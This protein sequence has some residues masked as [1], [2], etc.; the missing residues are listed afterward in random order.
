MSRYNNTSRYALDVSNQ[1]ASRIP[2]SPTS[3][4]TYVV[5]AR[6]SLESIAAAHLGSSHRYWEIADINPQ[7][8]F[9][10]DLP[11]GTLL[12]LPA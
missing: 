3:Y 6:D 1:S 12:R 4:M 8:K 9:P 5:K 7:I 10:L 11:I 2:A